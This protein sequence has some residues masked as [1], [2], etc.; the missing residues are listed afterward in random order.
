[1]IG[2]MEQSALICFAA[3]I[4]RK[5]VPFYIACE[6]FGKLLC[7]YAVGGVKLNIVISESVADNIAAVGGL[8]NKI[9]FIKDGI[10]YEVTEG[11]VIK[12]AFA[13]YTLNN[14]VETNGGKIYLPIVEFSELLGYESDYNEDRNM[15]NISEK[16]APDQS[17]N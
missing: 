16:T 9:N 3:V 17:S 13:D 8:G 12:R 15:M 11:N 4:G 7:L 14:S 1:M 6:S 10:F 2:K 5:S